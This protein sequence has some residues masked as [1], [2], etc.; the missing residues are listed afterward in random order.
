[1]EIRCFI[2][3]PSQFFGPAG[4]TMDLSFI[5]SMILLRIVIRVNCCRDS[6]LDDVLAKNCS[7]FSS[8]HGGGT[9]DFGRN[10]L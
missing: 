8:F 9:N 7:L 2:I 10:E 5:L 4:W 6:A 3:E 1:M